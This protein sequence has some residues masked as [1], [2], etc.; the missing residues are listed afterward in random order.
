MVDLRTEQIKTLRLEHITKRFP[1]V[2]ACDDISLSVGRGE[3]LALVGEN[4]AGKT[5]LMNII[6]GLYQSDDGGIV[7]NDTPVRF[8][9]P[10]DAIGAGLGMVHQQYML[11]PNMTVLENVALGFRQA[12]NPLKLDYA[13]I[14]DRVSEITGRYALPVEPDAYVWQ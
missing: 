10:R 6:M 13:M 12:W 1:G 9:S 3:I 7:I 11:V 8:H 14:R 4:G 2:L 5:T